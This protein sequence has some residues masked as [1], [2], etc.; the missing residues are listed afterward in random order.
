MARYRATWPKLYEADAE[1]GSI[2]KAK[3][4]DKWGYFIFQG[5]LWKHGAAGA[6]L[7]VPQEDS[8]NS[9]IEIL[10]EMHDSKTAGHMG[11]RRTLAKLMGNFYWKGMYGDCVKYV[12]S[13]HRCQVSKIDR[14]ARMGEPR[15]LQVPAAPWDVVHMDWITGLPRSPE[16]Y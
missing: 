9:K 4:D 12:E 7:C 16:G 15:A 5:L 6:R 3:G 13:C 14:R 8:N 2:W 10:R 11:T 1:L